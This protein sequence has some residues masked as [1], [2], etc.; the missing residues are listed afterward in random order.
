[1][2]WG[3]LLHR[4]NRN[5][6][7]MMVWICLCFAGFVSVV[8]AQ[9]VDTKLIEYL[10][11]EKDHLNKGI[12]QNLPLPPQS[13]QQL[14][15]QQQDNKVRLTLLQ[16]KIMSLE[17]FLGHQ[18]KQQQ[19][20]ASRLK[21]IQQ[22]P[23]NDDSKNLMREIAAQNQSNNDVLALIAVD[24][25][26]AQQYQQRLLE[27]RQQLEMWQ[28][29]FNEQQRLDDLQKRIQTLEEGR[30][31]LYNK[32]VLLAQDSKSS[33]QLLIEAQ[34][35][36]NNQ[37]IILIQYRISEL[38]LQKKLINAE[39]LLVRNQDLKT[40]Q[41]V[42]EIYEGV[43]YQLKSI[44]KSLKKVLEQLK[45]EAVVIAEPSLKQRFLVIQQ[46]ASLRLKEINQAQERL[47]QDLIEKQLL[48]KKQLA[49]RQDF[50]QYYMESWPGIAAQLL[51]V[52]SKVYLYIKT[53]ILSI[54]SSFVWQSLWSSIFL[55]F[56]WTV[57][58]SLAIM[59]RRSLRRLSLNKERSTL[60][61]RLYDVL[62][63][64]VQR[65]LAQL[66]LLAGFVWLFFVAHLP[67][68]TYQ[69]L[70]TLLLLWLGF[71][72][73]I[74]TARW[75]LLE[76][77]YDDSGQ[78]VKLYYR[79]KWLLL[80]GGWTTA[81]MILSQHLP[82]SLLLQDIFNRLFML[83]FLA[84]SWVMWKSKDLFPSLLLPLM[85]SKKRYLRHAIKLLTVLLPLI[86][87]TTAVI[88]LIGYINLAWTMSRHQAYLVLLITGYV[89]LRG[90]VF[91]ATEALSNWML[92]SMHNGW[93]WIEVFLKP[94][95]KIL[96]IS[97]CFVGIMALFQTFGW[98]SDAVLMGRLQTIFHYPFVN[99]SG[100][101]ITLASTLNFIILLCSFIWMA[102]WTREFSYRWLYRHSEDPGIR[103][104][105]SAF[106]QYAVVI[107]GGFISLRVLGL[108][109]SGMS[110][111]LG[112]LA[113]G[114]GF[115]LRDFAS[116]II[117]GLSL[118]I[119]RPV[120]EGDLITLG[121][122]EG[123]VA[124]IGI[125]S[126]RVSSW[127]N[128]EVLIP[129]AEA[130]NKPFTNWTHQDSVVRTVVPIKVSREDSALVV[131]DLILEVLATIPEILNEPPAQVFLKKIDDALIEF[132]VR[133]FIN[134]QIH[135]RFEIRS[136]LLFALIARFEEEGIRA[137]IPPIAI[138]LQGPK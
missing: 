119:E 74:L 18:R 138:D 45:L 25:S 23:L 69:L 76:G 2:N 88:G 126:M 85:K 51:Q 47:H 70:M 46:T 29:Q 22:A 75:L 36:L 38:E 132:E 135:T 79:L 114:M 93:L 83:F 27:E 52:P 137:P 97:L 115:G 17:S 21:I 127:D 101:Y 136:K 81:L 48:L 63:I 37:A 99:V 20:L 40:I 131:Q 43:S 105:L 113:V 68:S 106:T 8:N 15:V 55:Y 122:Y 98:S 60:S 123:R 103:N 32:N 10:Q 77:L 28:A 39:Y 57:I 41:T 95:D 128:M 117:G 9:A 67:G 80:F 118:L 44:E 78:D 102:K 24:L 90:I 31:N 56:G 4:Q 34:S 72:S 59:L 108:D 82:L 124:H 66:S 54:Q 91:D 42:T 12:Q 73:L 3:L 11:Q 26:L 7:W 109:F 13:A 35:L 133:Y 104:S 71:R 120:R 61:G 134:V 50:A 53:L 129:N 125:R 5:K 65:N 87:L 116:N 30:A 111:I 130:F 1:M 6:R 121:E 94:L 96:R 89:L 112:G 16:A 62:L 110:M 19:Q 64:L 84:L 14:S 49:L 100:M 107:L 58:A 92:A 33:N 86:L